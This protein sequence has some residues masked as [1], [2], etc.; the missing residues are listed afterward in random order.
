MAPHPSLLHRLWR[1][2]Q[3]WRRPEREAK[4]RESQEQASPRSSDGVFT[5]QLFEDFL[6]GLGVTLRGER[7]VSLR[8]ETEMTGLTLLQRS[9]DYEALYKVDLV[10]GHP[11]LLVL[12]PTA[13]LLRFEGYLVH[14]DL[15]HPLFG[16]L[17][18]LMTTQ[19]SPAFEQ[20]R[21]DLEEW[22]LYALAE[23]MKTLFWAGFSAG[24]AFPPEIVVERLLFA[25][26]TFQTESR[27]DEEY[28]KGEG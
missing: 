27:L 5:E 10:A 9:R 6:N 20:G 7:M 23:S 28:R 8:Q 11:R 15:S 2:V 12:L 4:N 1:H 17:V 26:Q 14:L 25:A 21:A 19:G 16:I 3:I 13:H 18:P 22:M 24:R